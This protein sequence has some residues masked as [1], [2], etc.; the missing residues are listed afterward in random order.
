MD[1]AQ[2]NELVANLSMMNQLRYFVVAQEIPPWA[3]ILAMFDTKLTIPPR[4][5]WV[6]FNYHSIAPTLSSS[7]SPEIIHTVALSIH[8]SKKELTT[9]S[10]RIFELLEAVLD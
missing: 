9:P 6:P 7:V 10:E 5:R 8:P 1:I 3:L 2:D 4:L